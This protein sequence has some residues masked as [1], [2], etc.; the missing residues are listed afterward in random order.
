M[1]PYAGQT[2]LSIRQP[3]AWMILNCG[4]DIEN[5]SWKT[6]FRGRVLIHASKGMTKTEYEEAYYTMIRI[7]RS[8][9]LPAF[10]VLQRGGIVGEVEIVGCVTESASPWFF[11]DYGLVLSNAKPLPFYECKGTVFPLFWTV[12]A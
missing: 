9:L 2:A 5:R 6:N 4:K 3:W 7:N 12:P 1:N 11:G 10:H 8:L